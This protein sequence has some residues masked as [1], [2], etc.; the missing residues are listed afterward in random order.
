MVERWYEYAHERPLGSP[1]MAVAYMRRNP[2]SAPSVFSSGVP[3]LARAARP[4]AHR[5][6]TGPAR[7]RAAL[8]LLLSYERTPLVFRYPPLLTS[9]APSPQRSTGGRHRAWGGYRFREIFSEI[10][11]VGQE[12]EISRNIAYQAG[13]VHSDLHLD[14]QTHISY[15]QTVRHSDVTHPVC[16]PLCSR[17]HPAPRLPRESGVARGA[18]AVTDAWRGWQ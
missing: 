8:L 3:R 15:A 16:V 2:Q 10:C 17:S 11:P 18:A 14:T 12:R 9:N 4:S 5:I 13:V 6:S 7:T 1:H